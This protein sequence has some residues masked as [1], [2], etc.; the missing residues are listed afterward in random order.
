MWKEVPHEVLM[1]RC[2]DPTELGTFVSA[3]CCEVCETGY[4]LPRLVRQMDR[5]MDIELIRLDRKIKR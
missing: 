2:R 1:F 4:L 3:V 5:C